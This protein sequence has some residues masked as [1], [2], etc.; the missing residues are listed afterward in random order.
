MAIRL[1]LTSDVGWV[2]LCAARS[3]AQSGDVYLDDGHHM[4]LARKFWQDYPE[5]GIAA[6]P[7]AV[8]ATEREESN[9]ANRVEWDEFFGEEDGPKVVVETVLVSRSMSEGDW[10]RTLKESRDRLT[11]AMLRMLNE[12]R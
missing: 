10:D 1:R 9:N 8:A 5:C 2:A 6:E 12:P 3:V 4:A 11:D 7:E